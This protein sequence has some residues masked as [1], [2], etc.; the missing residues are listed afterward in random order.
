MDCSPPCRN[1]QKDVDTMLCRRRGPHGDNLARLRHFGVED[2][3]VHEQS[4]QTRHLKFA[5]T[6]EP[7][8]YIVVQDLLRQI[9]FDAAKA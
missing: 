7:R 2:L 4:V 8:N 6:A 5:K 9:D 3:L 1:Q